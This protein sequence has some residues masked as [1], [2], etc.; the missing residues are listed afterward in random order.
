VAAFAGLG[1]GVQALRGATKCVA[2]GGTWLK[3]QN[4]AIQASVAIG[5]A[6]AVNGYYNGFQA[7]NKPGEKGNAWGHF[8]EATLH[9]L[10]VA[11]AVKYLR[12]AECFVAGTPVLVEYGSKPI[13]QIEVGDKVW[14]FDRTSGAWLIAPVTEAFRLASNRLVELT[15]ESGQQIVG[16]DG[17]P[18]W[19]LEGRDLA[20]R[21]GGDHGAGETSIMPGRWVAMGDLQPGDIL[22]SRK[23]LSERVAKLTNVTDGA[24]VYNLEVAG[25]ATYAV[26]SGLLVH[27][28][29]RDYGLDA[30]KGEIAHAKA[31]ATTPSQPEVVTPAPGTAPTASTTTGT[32]P[33]SAGTTAASK[34]TRQITWSD[35]ERMVAQHVSG[36]APRR[37][38]FYPKWAERESNWQ[39][40]RPDHYDLQTK[41]IVET[42]I[43]DWADPNLFKYGTEANEQ[44]R[45]K[46][47]QAAQDGW[48]LQ[49]A[50]RGRL[51]VEN[52]VWYVRHTL[53]ESGP[54]SELTRLLRANGITVVVFP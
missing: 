2:A 6:G 40:R 18:F 34:A 24:V 29:P 10:G 26:A 31:K 30:A 5:G 38:R 37:E 13:E 25:P 3:V 51:P 17:H 7:L 53:P 9:L 15:T 16:T 35:Y 44:Y 33:A 50:R 23:A 39:V 48:L 22:A 41:T 8:G 43:L 46:L 42:T 11:G 52:V 32:R 28:A 14:A 4:R 54:A 19:V 21:R 45:R 1:A 12:N 47:V 36:T 27:N 20:D 49:N